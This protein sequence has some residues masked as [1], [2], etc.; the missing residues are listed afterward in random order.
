MT[1]L[2]QAPG[3]ELLSEQ[4]MELCAKVPMLPMHYLATKD[5]VVREA[6]RNGSLTK[7]GMRRVVNVPTPKEEVLFDFFVKEAG[8]G[9]TA[10]TGKA[11]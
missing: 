5:A 3:A 8:L 7:E 6:Y 1:D 2:S 10:G 11:K 9:G 4:E